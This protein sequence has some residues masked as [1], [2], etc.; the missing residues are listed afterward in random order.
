MD[1][2]EENSHAKRGSTISENTVRGGWPTMQTMTT[3]EV[4]EGTSVKKGEEA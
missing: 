1:P 2:R 3:R 4:E